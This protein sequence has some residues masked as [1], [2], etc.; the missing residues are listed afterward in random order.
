MIL[1][2]LIVGGMQASRK[3]EIIDRIMSMEI[4]EKCHGCGCHLTNHH[5]GIPEDDPFITCKNPNCDTWKDE[6][7]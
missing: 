3:K 4:S 5:S 2:I 1:K 7:K 6:S